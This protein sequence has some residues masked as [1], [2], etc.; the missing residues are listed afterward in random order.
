MNVYFV[1]VFKYEKKNVPRLKLLT[2]KLLHGFGASFC[3]VFSSQ[4]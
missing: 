1:Y 3:I 4:L 2:F